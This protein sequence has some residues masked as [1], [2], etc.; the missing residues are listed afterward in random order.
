MGK[1]ILIGFGIICN[2]MAIYLCATLLWSRYQRF[3]SERERRGDEA[4][5][6]PAV[7]VIPQPVKMRNILFTY[8]SATAKTVAIIGDFNDWTPEPMNRENFNWNIVK[9]VPPGKYLYNFVIDGRPVLDPNNLRPPE[10]NNRGFRSS[11]LIV[12]P[13][14]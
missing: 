6:I 11:V 5:F 3:K 4:I 13:L 14:E 1:K 8:R 12:K 10:D 2:L 9:R 7:P